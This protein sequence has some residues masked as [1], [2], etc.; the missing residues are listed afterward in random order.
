L[1][2]LRH[3]YFDLTV[4]DRDLLNAARRG[5]LVSWDQGFFDLIILPGRKPLVTLRD[6]AESISALPEAEHGLPHW[7]TAIE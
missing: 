5:N 3:Q 6:A 7:V 1:A 2:T 4:H